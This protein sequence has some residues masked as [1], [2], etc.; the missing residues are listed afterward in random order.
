[1]ANP[2]L[3]KIVDGYIQA[4]RHQYDEATLQRQL[5]DAGIDPELVAIALK[6]VNVSALSELKRQPDPQ[7]PDVIPAQAPSLFLYLVLLIIASFLILLAFNV[8][9][10]DWAGILVNLSTE[11]IGAIVILVIVDRR[12]RRSELRAIREYAETSSVWF[13]S[14]FSREISTAISYSKVFG[15][16]LRKIQPKPYIERPA[17]ET[18]LDKYTQGFLLYGDAGSG[19][20]TLLQRIAAKQAKSVIRHP[21]RERIPILFPMRLWSNGNLLEQV[22]QEM[23]RYSPVK[24]HMFDRW[25]ASGRALVIFDGLNE[26]LKPELALREIEDLRNRYPNISLIVSFRA[27]LL[28]GV[29][30]V[31][32]YLDL[33]K[34]EMPDM[35]KEEAEK[36]FILFQH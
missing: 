9:Q 13:A 30:A 34:I 29:P 1:M 11:I 4:N 6:H 24:R 5:L 35:T 22:W 12:L 36:L 23:C 16:Q 3:L 31:L 21:R 32:G 14:L 25:L 18:L 15:L 7:P 10:P 17:L 8:K 27:F 33:P 19:K 28:A 26:S 2:L 20:S